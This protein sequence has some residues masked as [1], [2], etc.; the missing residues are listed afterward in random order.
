[1]RNPFTARRPWAAFLVA[2]VLNPIV[3]M[4]FIGRARLAGLYFLLTLLSF[5]IF[6]SVYPMGF[7]DLNFR[8]AA[9]FANGLIQLIGAIHAAY[10]A[11]KH[12]MPQPVSWYGRWYVVLAVPLVYVGLVFANQRLVFPIYY[13]PSIAMEPTLGLDDAVSASRLGYRFR[14]PTRGD[15]IVYCKPERNVCFIKRVIGVPGDRIEI[16]NGFVIL[17]GKSLQRTVL[18]YSQYLQQE[19][20]PDGRTYSITK[21]PAP[22]G[23]YDDFPEVTVPAERYYVLGDNRDNSLDSRF[24]DVGFVARGNIVGPV[25]VRFF[26]GEARRFVWQPIR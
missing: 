20:L 19:Q 2:L 3:G 17:N 10:L 1:M 8:D 11:W 18:S 5:A 24:S 26:D 15:P 9:S 21:N 13:L 14:D 16:R 7:G 4:L 22:G 12:P 25:V 23:P 6:F